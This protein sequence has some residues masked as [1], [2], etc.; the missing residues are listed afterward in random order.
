MYELE[1][2]GGNEILLLLDGRSIAAIYTEKD[3]YMFD[4]EQ[5]VKKMNKKEEDEE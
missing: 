3:C 4:I 2:R 5:M 1:Y